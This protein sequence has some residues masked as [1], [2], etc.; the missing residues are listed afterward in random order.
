M[1]SDCNALFV[2]AIAFAVKSGASASATYEQIL[3]HADKIG[4]QGELRN[5]LDQAAEA[6]PPDYITQ[7]GWVLIR[8]R[9]QGLRTRAH[10][11]GVVDVLIEA[12]QLLVGMLFIR[13]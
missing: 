10:E 12:R 5:V 11:D 9:G 7:Q 4:I 1:C 6:P 8:Q 13:G 3:R 2:V